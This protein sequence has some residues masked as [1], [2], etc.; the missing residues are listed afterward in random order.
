MASGATFLFFA[1]MLAS[2]GR[3]WTPAG[4]QRIRDKSL[5]PAIAADGGELLDLDASRLML[6]FFGSVTV[7]T[8]FF[9]AA[10]MRSA[11]TSWPRSSERSKLPLHRVL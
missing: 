7:N 6:G 3:G 4:L 8:P 1:D 2:T 5:R 9:S 10:P 11:S